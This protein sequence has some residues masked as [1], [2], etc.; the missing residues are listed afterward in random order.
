MVTL[1]DWQE[2]GAPHR[3]LRGKEVDWR[4]DLEKEVRGLNFE[5]LVEVSLRAKRRSLMRGREGKKDR[6]DGEMTT[7]VPG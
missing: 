7:L 2:D 5:Y 3:D 6:R 4:K 1:Q